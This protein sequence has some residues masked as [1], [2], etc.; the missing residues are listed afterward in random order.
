MIFLYLGC[1]TSKLEYDT[2]HPDVEPESER[3]EKREFTERQRK[4]LEDALT[5]ANTAVRDPLFETLLRARS[6]VYEWDAGRLDRVDQH[7]GTDYVSYFLSE[8]RTRG[9]PTMGMFVAKDGYTND[10]VTGSTAP[11]SEKINFNVDNLDRSGRT[12][13]FVAG[14]IVHERMHSFCYKHRSNDSGKDYNL[15]DMAYHAGHITIIV[16]LYRANNSRPIKKPN[17]P[18]CKSLVEDLRKNKIIE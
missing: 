1:T 18:I 16:S 8:Y 2:L 15:C 10:D 6:H 13:V 17:M 7:I 12:P 9:L 5:I 11:C 14:T 4:K 3:L